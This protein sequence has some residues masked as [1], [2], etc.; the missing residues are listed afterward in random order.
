MAFSVVEERFVTM[1]TAV[2]ILGLSLAA[3]PLRLGLVAVVLARR[4]PM[5]NLAAFWLGGM[6]A[7]IGLGLAVLIIF[8]SIAITAIDHMVSALGNLRSSVVIL[9]GGGLEVTLGVLLLLLSAG[10]MARQRAQQRV[11]ATGV[12]SVMV[13]QRPPN[14]FERL[15][16]RSQGMLKHDAAWPAFLVGLG[17]ATPPVE[18]VM[19][20]T[21]IMASGATITTQMMAFVVFTFL[22]LALVEIPLLAYLATP[23]RAEA[24]MLR[25]NGWLHAY[26]GR[27]F[28]TMLAI[29]GV[30]LVVKGVRG[31]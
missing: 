5:R 4:R 27:I 12:P 17:S 15:A 30:V 31:L 23:R 8:R 28:Q 9:T 1:W 14:T 22:V 7:S 21:V 26:R 6:V 11:A 2:F 29:S 18:C 13:Q 20:L 16:G 3:D 24:V 19:L 10:L 25:L